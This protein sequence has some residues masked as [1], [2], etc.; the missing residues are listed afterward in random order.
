MTLSEIKVSTEV[1]LKP[2]DVAEVLGCGAHTIR[3]QAHE[4]PENL[5]FPVIV[6]G[7]RVRIPRKAFLRFIGEEVDE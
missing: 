6:T 1:T 5:G 7:S 2:T 3:V 4:Y